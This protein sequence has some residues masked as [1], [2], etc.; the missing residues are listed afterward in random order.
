MVEAVASYEDFL[1]RVGTGLMG[2]A[3][4]G[5]ERERAQISGRSSRKAVTIPGFRSMGLVGLYGSLSSIIALS[6]GGT[7]GNAM[8]I[9]PAAGIVMLVLIYAYAR[10]VKAGTY[11]FTTYLVVLLTFL[12]GVMAGMGLILEA[13]G[14]SVAV[15]M[16]LALKD[17]IV[18]LARNISYSELIAMLEVAALIVIVGP[19][20]R[21]YSQLVPLFNLFTAYLFFTAV[22]AISFGSYAAARIWGAQALVAGAFLASLVNSEATMSSVFARPPKGART[23]ALITSLIVSAMQLR[24]SILAAIALLIAGG[25]PTLLA[26]LAIVAL[27]SIVAAKYSSDAIRG[28]E[29]PIPQPRNPLDWV[30]ALRGA[31]IYVLLTI[32]AKAIVEAAPQGGAL[33]AA[34]VGLLGGGASATAALLSLASTAQDIG[35]ANALAGMLL[36]MFSATLNKI[37]YARA[38]GAKGDVLRGVGVASLALSIPPLLASILVLVAF[39]I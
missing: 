3:L 25:E 36:S 35:L 17:P 28:I 29:T 21:E 27:A 4:V 14:V 39:P 13:A 11:G 31:L 38:A 6:L 20:V 22:V 18:K 10:M 34:I 26:P 33:A 1:L 8:M 16:L 19:L 37:F 24:S 7:A 15:S 30:A 32:M 9:L 23:S 12:V 2:G 5:L